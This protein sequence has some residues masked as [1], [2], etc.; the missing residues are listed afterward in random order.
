MERLLQIVSRMN[1]VVG[2]VTKCSLAFIVLITVAD[3]ILR[4]FR[5]PIVGTYELVAFSGAV[6]IGFS[7]PLTSWAKGHIQVDFFIM[8]L[9]Q[10]TRKIINTLTKSLGI[11]LFLLIGWNVIILGND[12]RKAG[13]V[14][15]TLEFPFYIVAYGIGICSFLQCLVLLCDIVKI[16]GDKYE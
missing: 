13:E 12:L 4:S 14:S 16:L 3:V 11:G 7:I 5:R 10:R 6:A 8:K 9:S 1:K 2:I 15:F